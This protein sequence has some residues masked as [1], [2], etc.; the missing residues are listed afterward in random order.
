FPQRDRKY[1]RRYGRG[2]PVQEPRINRYFIQRSDFLPVPPQLADY[3]ATVG[4]NSNSDSLP[5]YV[6]L[7]IVHHSRKWR[8]GYA[9]RESQTVVREFRRQPDC[10]SAPH[11]S[12]APDKSPGPTGISL[13]RQ[14]W[15]SSGSRFRIPVVPPNPC[16]NAR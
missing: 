9:S 2:R 15:K 4:A 8:R 1:A 16:C 12:A 13:L 7:I 5:R 11:V 14:S 6:V 3:L 10:S